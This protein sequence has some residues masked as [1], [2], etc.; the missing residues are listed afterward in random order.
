MNDVAIIGGGIAG[1]TLSIQLLRTDPTLKVFVCDKQ[2][3]PY[4]ERHKLGE[5]L[6]E[7]GSFYL[8]EIVGVGDHLREHHVDKAGLRFYRLFT[9][10]E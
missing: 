5:A 1:L 9:R 6:I 8:R 2:S 3:Y 7:G 10:R 4:P